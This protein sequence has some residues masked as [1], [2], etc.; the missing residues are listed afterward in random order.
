[1]C[2][3]VAYLGSPI[4][5]DEVIIKPSNSL[6]QQS[7]HALES[8]MTVNGDG[9]GLGWYDKEIKEEPA[10][11]VSLFP[12]WN[13]K[14]LLSIASI[15][16]SRCFLAHIRAAT[17]GGVSVEN[18]HPFRYN[19]F[20]MMHNGGIEDFD[21]IKLDLIRLLDEAAFLWIKGQSDTQYILALFMTISR[22]M[23]IQKDPRPAKL[24]D[25]FRKTF[26]EIEKLKKSKGLNSVSNYN[27]VLSNG[28]A[29]VA[30]RF[31]SMPEVD[32]R[33]LYFAE[34]VS[35]KLNTEGDLKFE[36]GKL[37]RS[38]ALISSEKLTEDEVYWKEIP[39]NHAV[40]IEE[41]MEV[42][43]FPLNL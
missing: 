36:K 42:T 13:D 26:T 2:R 28:R 18:C 3:F 30:T 4:R 24:I 20:L 31:S 35:C 7:Y 15:T 9:F 38:A 6:I 16:K 40:Y 32:N 34:N 1:M 27:I 17:V 29:M 22:A 10:L 23:E 12:A 8:T 11:Y 33:T 5:I 39:F 21:C 19:E 43:L 41:D 14:N 37:E 25:C